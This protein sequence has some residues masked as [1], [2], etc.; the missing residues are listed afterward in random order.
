[1]LGTAVGKRDGRLVGGKVG[2][3]DGFAVGRNEVGTLLGR[4]EGCE[5]VGL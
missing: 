2:T 3:A 4:S 5:L 1:M